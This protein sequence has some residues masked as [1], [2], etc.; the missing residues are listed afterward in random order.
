M[1]FVTWA[2]KIRKIVYP[3]HPSH[4]LHIYFL[5]IQSVVI[6]SYLLS[7]IE[8][9]QQPLWLFCCSKSYVNCCFI[10][11]L[12]QRMTNQMCFFD[13]SCSEC[14]KETCASIY[15][16]FFSYFNVVYFYRSLVSTTFSASCRRNLYWMQLFSTSLNLM[17]VTRYAADRYQDH[18]P[19]YYCSLVHHALRSSDQWIRGLVYKNN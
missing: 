10:Q 19:A 4:F 18:M 1:R 13:V 2:R 8:S 6:M 3:S 5:H 15:L 17:M 16:I 12:V 7:A 11:F 14:I 9:K